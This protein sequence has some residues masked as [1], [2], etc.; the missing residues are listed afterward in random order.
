MSN[1]EETPPKLYAAREPV[2]PR[3]VK[4]TFRSLKWWLMIVT[5]GIYYLSPWIRWDRGP[6]LPDQA[7]SLVET[8][9]LKGVL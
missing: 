8:Y 9:R 5:L 7:K 2:F 4:G 3:K 1:I 6:N